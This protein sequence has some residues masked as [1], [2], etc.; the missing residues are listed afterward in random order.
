MDNPFPRCLN[1]YLW[2]L[3]WLQALG[4]LFGCWTSNLQLLLTF[5]P[6]TDVLILVSSSSWGI[7]NKWLTWLLYSK[8]CQIWHSFFE[9]LGHLFRLGFPLGGCN[10]L[11]FILYVIDSIRYS[12]LDHV[13]C[14]IEFGNTWVCLLCIFTLV[15]GSLCWVL[16][17]SVWSWLVKNTTKDEPLFVTCCECSVGPSK[18]YFGIP[19]YIYKHRWL[20][21]LVVSL[22]FVYPTTN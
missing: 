3:K 11:G 20:L 2:L 19:K 17:Y 5:G 15:I 7:L 21:D 22:Y 6:K 14:N 8:Y 4:S 18:Y 9:T 12:F 1:N 16:T 10:V 13:V